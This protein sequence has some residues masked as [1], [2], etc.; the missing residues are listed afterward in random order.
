MIDDINTEIKKICNELIEEAES[1]A[2]LSSVSHLSKS[3]VQ[4]SGGDIRL[5]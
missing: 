5:K 4:F 3:K 2:N 1:I